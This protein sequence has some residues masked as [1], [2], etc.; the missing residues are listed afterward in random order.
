MIYLDNAAT[1]KIDPEVLDAMMPYLTKEYGNPGGLYSVG[2]N[3]KKA[4]EDARAQ[5]AEF[6]GAEPEQIVFT[7]GGSEANNM[8]IKSALSFTGYKH[9]LTDKTEHDSILHAVKQIKNYIFTEFISVN[10]YGQV[11]FSDF[12][13]KMNAGVGLVSVMRTNNE[14]GT[15]NPVIEIGDYIKKCD[16]TVLFHTDCVQTAGCRK[17]DVKEMNCDLLSISSHKIHGPKGVG[18]LFIKDK[19]R[20]RP[21]INGGSYQE[22]GLR[23]GTENVAGIVGFGK[24]CEISGNT[25]NKNM[26]SIIS[27]KLAFYTELRY[28]LKRFRL[29]NILHSNGFSIS[30]QGKVLNLRFDGIDAQTLILMLDSLGVCISAGS[31]C[32]SHENKPSHVL[33]AMGLT[34]EEASSSVRISFSRMN[35]AAEAI[36]AAKIIAKC[37]SVLKNA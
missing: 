4:V 18:A 26:A 8:A 5:V 34:P 22:F 23:G 15:E 2:R 28:W 20:C 7:S 32:T 35:T 36:E 17:L 1:T 30:E 10:E 6:V 16:S 14:T 21:L 25:L 29:D 12:R 19:S 9:I 27:M 24:A 37:I 31:A 11:E 3:A 13:A 33:L